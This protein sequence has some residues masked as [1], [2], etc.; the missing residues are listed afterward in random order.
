M[1]NDSWKTAETNEL[2]KGLQ[3]LKT[4]EEF[5]NFLRDL[6]TEQEIETFA[7]RFKAAQMLDEGKSYR[8]IAKDT[9]MSTTT[10]TRISYWLE[11]GMGGYKNVISNLH[12]SHKTNDSAVL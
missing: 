12:H 3:T 11:R 1:N 8:A 2:I 7:A 4:K 5:E 9:G 6:M 10:I